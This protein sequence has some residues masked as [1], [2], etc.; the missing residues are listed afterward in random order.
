MNTL[1]RHMK[2]IFECNFIFL[3]VLS[4]GRFCGMREI[5]SKLQL[6]HV[7][8][9]L[10]HCWFDEYRQNQCNTN[11]ASTGQNQ[12]Q[13]SKLI[14]LQSNSRTINKKIILEI[15]VYPNR[16]LLQNLAP[17]DFLTVSKDLRVIISFQTKFT[18][19][20]NKTT[21]VFL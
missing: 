1:E 5:K 11:H 10:S 2:D 20:A 21:L 8:S 7:I 9:L 18:T 6:L 13:T 3:S 15:S 16:L 14:Q 19:A 12:N 17:A 4:S